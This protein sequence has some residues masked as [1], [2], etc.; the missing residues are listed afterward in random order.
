VTISGLEPGEYQI[1]KHIFDKDHG[2]LYTKW[3]NTNS[4]YGLDEEIIE[5]IKRISHPALE[6]SDEIIR[7]DWSFYSYLL[8]N[9]VHFFDI[10]KVHPLT[11]D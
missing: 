7:G 5:H 9:A 3:L 8:L 1:R 6:V 4:K 2:A 11:L 10:R